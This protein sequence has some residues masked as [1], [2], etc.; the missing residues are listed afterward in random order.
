MYDRQSRILNTAKETI[1]VK[2]LLFPVA[3]RE[4]IKLTFSKCAFRVVWLT[5]SRLS[6]GAGFPHTAAKSRSEKKCGP[7]PP[8]TTHTLIIFPMVLYRASCDAKKII[9][10]VC[11]LYYPYDIFP[12]TKHLKKTLH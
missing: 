6:G 8:R 9:S 5:S 12:W 7:T 3:V 11:Q 4:D 1:H 2:N 10:N